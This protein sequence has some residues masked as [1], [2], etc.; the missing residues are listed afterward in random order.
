MDDCWRRQGGKKA[1][2]PDLI[3]ATTNMQARGA[4]A[5]L[6]V[7]ETSSYKGTTVVG[8]ATSGQISGN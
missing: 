1:K 4:F 7:M 5:I 6:S 2:V 8:N 3:C